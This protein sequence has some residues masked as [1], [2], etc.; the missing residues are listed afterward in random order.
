MLLYILKGRFLN[1][2]VFEL[3]CLIFPCLILNMQFSFFFSFVDLYPF[4]WFFPF[5]LCNISHAQPQAQSITLIAHLSLSLNNKARVSIFQ[6][7]I[8]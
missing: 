6:V 1:L 4:Q 7:K 3:F 5:V 2:V 8:K